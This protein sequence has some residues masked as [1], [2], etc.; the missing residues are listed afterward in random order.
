MELSFTLYS[1][2]CEKV[3]IS[4]STLCRITFLYSCGWID[5]I[6]WLKVVFA[7]STYFLSFMY[8]ALNKERDRG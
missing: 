7:F 1:V 5:L 4:D 6:P 8:L 3:K 2:L